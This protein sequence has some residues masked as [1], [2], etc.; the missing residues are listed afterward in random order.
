MSVVLLS[1]GT[2]SG[3]ALLVERL[4][5][6]TG[7][8][9]V[10]RENLMELVNR[11]G[12]LA[13]RVLARMGSA[14][15]AYEDFCELRRPY[16]I[17]MRAALLEYSVEGDLVYHGFSGHLLLPPF[18][19]VRTI[20]IQAPL[21]MRVTMTMQRL[22]CGEEEARSYIARDDEER[23]R[24][25]RYMYG[26]DIR[27]PALYDLCINLGRLSIDSACNFIQAVMKDPECQVTTGSRRAARDALT[28]ARVEAALVTDPRTESIEAGA[29]IV[30]GR[31]TVT[32]PYVDDARRD[33]VLE[34]ARGVEGV[35]D[36]EY[37]YGFVPE[38]T[39]S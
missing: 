7:I 3:V 38:L 2:M 37:R 11:H 27:D 15:R 22:V 35:T 34:I 24:W 20:R 8:R 28:A 29:Q 12:E 36:V 13:R 18:A 26:R 25:G 14:A 9:C 39:A 32:G 30:E 33:A 5:Q 10:S 6:Q 4:H 23:V 17:L 16:L 21:E 31:V 1:R 19:H